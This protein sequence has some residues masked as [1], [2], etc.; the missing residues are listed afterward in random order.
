M[1][2]HVTMHD[3]HMHQAPPRCF[4]CRRMS[5]YMADM[6]QEMEQVMSAF[7]MPTG[8]AGH[9]HMCTQ[10]SSTSALNIHIP[11]HMRECIC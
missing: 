11:Q 5:D 2:V 3:R 8:E 7:G 6:Q 1:Q 4:P 10:L 9:A